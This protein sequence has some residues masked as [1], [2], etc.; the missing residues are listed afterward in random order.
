MAAT[1]ES[2][3]ERLGWQDIAPQ[4]RAGLDLL[5]D[6]DFDSLPLEGR[7]AILSS[8]RE[9]GRSLEQLRICE[10]CGLA[11]LLEFAEGERCRDCAA[12][13]A[14]G[15][16]AGD[17]G[18]WLGAP[19]RVAAEIVGLNGAALSWSL[20]EARAPSRPLQLDADNEDW[21]SREAR[22]AEVRLEQ[23]RRQEEDARRAEQER[24]AEEERR[25]E[26]EALRL[27]EEAQRREEE[28]R[29]ALEEERR[30]RIAEQDRRRQSEANMLKRMEEERAKLEAE[31]RA[32]IEA[33]M[34]AKFEAEQRAKDELLAAKEEELNRKRQ[35][36][37]DAVRREAMESARLKAELEARL[38]AEEDERQRL[39][40]GEAARLAAEEAARRA[41][42]EAE[43]RGVDEPTRPAL[44]AVVGPRAGKV[45]RLPDLP[46]RGA[47]DAT[48]V[49][50][51]GSG[52]NRMARLFVKQTPAWIDGRQQ[53]EGSEVDLSLGA[54]I[55]IGNEVY[56]VEE[57]GEMGSQTAAAMHFARQDR[58]PGGPWS[59]WNEDVLI[60]ASAQCQI[61]LVDDGID[62]VHA[63]VVTRYGQVVLEDRS[64]Q[65]G[66]DGIW[67]GEQKRPWL[68]LTP[69]VIFRLGPRGP[70][71]VVKLGEA[72]TKAAEKARAM[73]PS[74]HNRTV[75]EI[76]NGWGELIKKAFLFTRREVRFGNS[77][78]APGD[79]T[80][81]LNEWP[82]VLGPREKAA[83]ALKQGGLQLTREGVDLRW[84][85]GAPMRLNDEPMERGKPQP[86]KR[87][88]RIDIGE[89]LGFD[90]RVFRSP[91]NIELEDGP[92]RLGMKGGHPFECLRLDRDST[93]HSYFFIVRMMRI[94]SDSFA[95][96]R[97]ELPGVDAAHCRIMFAQGKFFVAAPKADARV[98]LGDIEM[99]PGVTFPLEINT[100]IRIGEATLLFRPVRDEDFLPQEIAAALEEE[101]RK[102]AEDEARRRAEDAERQRR[103]EE[104]MRQA[105]E[106]AELLRD[107]LEVERER[108]RN[109]REREMLEW[110][111][112]QDAYLQ[113][114]EQSERS[115][116]DSKEKAEREARERAEAEAKAKA[117]QEA[118]QRRK[119]EEARK[120]RIA[121]IEQSRNKGSM[122][123]EVRNEQ[124]TLVRRVFVFARR[125]V[126]FGN[127]AFEPGKEYRMLNELV[128]SPWPKEDAEI[129]LT[130]GAFMMAS[131]GVFVRRG[132][133]APMTLNARRLEP[134]KPAPL[135][136]KF[137]LTFGSSLE[138]HGQ[139]YKANN[140]K[141]VK[142]EVVRL[143]MKGG[144]PFEC[145]VMEREA[146]RHT[147]VFL[148]QSLRIGSDDKSPLR[149]DI[150]GV[151]PGHCQIMLS[152]GRLYIGAGRPDAPVF[153]DDV[154]IQPGVATPLRVNTVLS[155]GEARLLYREVAESDFMTRRR[156][157]EHFRSDDAMPQP[158]FF[159]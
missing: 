76:R 30:R 98:Y 149:L 110:Q 93:I 80:R 85:S 129:G 159:A 33:E 152:R 48:S 19:A 148:I 126:R 57:T 137:L 1:L 134:T 5:C 18:L 75:L 7:K 58:K 140:P 107:T 6:D 10:A 42:E 90:G 63:Q 120:Q 17:H 71:L 151:Q 59:F 111:A 82:L 133:G 55:Q 13:F 135:A 84:D 100:L 28:A 3:A 52:T 74:R 12:P 34:R 70:E 138:L 155:I 4:D 61:R 78:T 131:E 139:V 22:M 122:L 79:R 62:D 37:I 117:E 144:H 127:A 21:D 11:S 15:A 105:E 157:P 115:R 25:K 154:Q 54:T 153:L 60:G 109:A 77:V 2:L 69:G 106:E 43:R 27:A 83:I 24:R 150:P 50:I 143:G 64:K 53:S 119:I 103:Q 114:R 81:T 47:S 45:V 92:A 101:R 145:V 156:R 35:E 32:K 94:G 132:K 116:R 123:L 65:D 158:D 26:A 130:Q 38:V 102:E 86:L 67:V 104:T 99:D 73:K 16:E 125:E 87:R 108:L 112:R 128:L 91:T 66:D 14:G 41:A 95:P 89:R 29:Q 124:G 147:Y 20:A 40:A 51:I 97:L 118:E 49:Y 56:V 23:E 9:R 68:L 31:M 88:F 39:A 36:E 141:N 96:L 146:A 8:W 72:K 121:A 136:N 44:G 113:R 46:E 142:H